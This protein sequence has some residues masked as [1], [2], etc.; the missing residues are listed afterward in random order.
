MFWLLLVLPHLEEKAG[1]K[2]KFANYCYKSN[3]QFLY[4]KNS[5]TVQNFAYLLKDSSCL[6]WRF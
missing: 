5:S 2:V 4:L 6:S 1:F 3:I